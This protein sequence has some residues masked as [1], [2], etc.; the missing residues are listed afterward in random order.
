MLAAR[1]REGVTAA[2][3]TFVLTADATFVDGAAGARVIVDV[4]P[5][6]ANGAGT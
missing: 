6:A 4:T 5:R 1:L 2:R 3:V